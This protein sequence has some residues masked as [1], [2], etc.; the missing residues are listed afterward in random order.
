MNEIIIFLKPS[1][2]VA[3]FSQDF[4]VYQGSFNNFL[5][6]V[7][8]PESVLTKTISLSGD[9]STVAVNIGAVGVNKYG[10]TFQTEKHNLK[11]KK[12]FVKDGVRYKLYVSTENDNLDDL[13]TYSGTT[14]LIINVLEIIQGENANT[15]VKVIT[16]QQC[17][18]HVQPSAYLSNEKPIE[19]SELDKTNA[20]V[21][22]LLGI[23][24]NLPLL[25][26]IR[27]QYNIADM[28]A[29]HTFTQ[30]GYNEPLS[31][32]YFTTYIVP[33]LPG[34]TVEKTGLSVFSQ[35]LPDSESSGVIGYQTEY[36]AADEVICARTNK[37]NISQLNIG[38]CEVLENGI[39][40]IVNQEYISN[41]K[42][43]TDQN[44]A[45]IEKL[46][47]LSNTYITPLGEFP[48]KN[49]LP[50]EKELN[51]FV[52]EKAQ[53]Q[54]QNGD[55]ITFVL[56][57]ESGTDIIYLI[58]YSEVTQTW[59]YTAYPTI[60]AAENTSLGLIKGSSGDL[61]VNIENGEIKSVSTLNEESEQ[62]EVGAH[63]NRNSNA[64]SKN[65]TDIATNATNI[66]D[67][68]IRATAAE[69][70]NVEAIAAETTRAVT[71]ESELENAIQTEITRATTAEEINATAI[72]SE[73]TRAQTEEARLDNAKLEKASVDEE[74]LQNITF[75]L[76][77]DTNVATM[78][79]KNPKTGISRNFEITVNSAAS[80]ELT[81][82]MTAEMVQSLHGALGDIESLKYI[83]R[84]IQSF[85]TYAD[86]QL[87]DFSTIT[88]IQLN[89]YF[90]V[91]ADESR[92]EPT[93]K[94]KTTKYNCVDTKLPLT[95]DSFRFQSVVA[96]V[97]IQLATESTLGGV[98]SVNTNGYVYV[99]PTG[100]MKLVGY[101]AILTSM[102]NLTS[103]LSEESTRAK[104]AETA[105]ADAISE[106]VDRATAAEIANKTLIDNLNTSLT[107]ETNRAKAAEETNAIAIENEKTR[108]KEAEEE[109]ADAISAETTRATAAENTL[110]TTKAD[111]AQI[112]TKV[113]QLTQD[114][115]LQTLKEILLKS[116]I[117]R[118]TGQPFATL[119]ELNNALVD[120]VRIKA[121]EFEETIGTE[122]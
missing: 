118:T 45:D 34:Q 44:S 56:S 30:D 49:T 69:E 113:S 6:N 15:P 43:Q 96:T 98:L 105:N 72:A 92:T 79:I 94:D 51:A 7:A 50:T 46:Y 82:L 36:F 55:E 41:I 39:W 17:D 9:L 28:P 38:N 60:E 75:S 3:D 73:T 97:V 89:D 59:S 32:Y 70:T 107:A 57:V 119:A 18:L 19:V 90:I 120:G 52:L 54:P 12:D 99:E 81:G 77:G 122:E 10:K 8:V 2:S 66:T 103:A 74:Y 84:Q 4:N 116:F 87:F 85:P 47:R 64:I 78:S 14:T 11:W 31:A 16:S 121:G 27:T 76:N 71:K 101:D 88:D 21:N 33:T 61:S 26:N 68:V 63:L 106:E 35:I 111:I 1:G 58:K 117:N 86:A 112:P 53:R 29:G 100:A 110:N 37:L 102:A 42:N 22:H 91:A 93:E 80:P 83:G 20:N 65:K 104:A 108:A 95:I 67:E 114:G 23:V 109:N 115:D 25:G 24:N 13:T 5:I 40:K 62:E 48:T